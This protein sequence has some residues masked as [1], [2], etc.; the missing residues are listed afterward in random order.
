MDS[1]YRY[2]TDASVLFDAVNG[3]IVHE[4]FRLPFIFITSNLIA[5]RE[6][7]TP[8]FSEFEPLGLKK[9]ELSGPQI[10]AMARIRN[11]HKT[12]SI[13]DISAFILA[14]DQELILL[15]SDDVLRKFAE[16]YE[17]E[18]HGILWIL[19][20]LITNNILSKPEA[21]RVLQQILAHNSYLPKKECVD[22]IARWS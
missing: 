3:G 15:S 11:S 22:R 6:L 19:D 14:R 10:G 13:Y 12:L 8:P 20:S 1:P 21:S 4:M 2:V 16:S 17:T 5:E 9:E 7:K 18:V